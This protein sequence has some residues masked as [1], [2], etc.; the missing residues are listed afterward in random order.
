MTADAD[1]KKKVP[2]RN[3][4]LLTSLVG[5]TLTRLT[6]YSWWPTEESDREENVSPADVFSLTAG[7]VLL[8]FDTGLI[9]CFGS[10]P[11]LISVT[12]W[13]DDAGCTS[14]DLELHAI[15]AG[16][17]Q[18]SRALFAQMVGRKV[19]RITLLKRAP[20]NAKWEER[21]REVGLIIRFDGANDLVLAHGLHDDSDDF[22]VLVREQVKESLWS[23][24]SEVDIGRVATRADKTSVELVGAIAELGG[25]GPSV[26]EL[27]GKG[28]FANKEGLLSYLRRG[29][30]L[31]GSPA[32]MHDPLRPDVLAGA[33]HIR[34]DGRY[35][36]HTWL[37]Y[38]VKNYDVALPAAFLEHV[39]RNGYEV[40]DDIDTRALRLGE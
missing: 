17:P 32:L 6:R 31:I 7:P 1:E 35:A 20:K 21:P 5:A 25:E 16:D 29:K 37:E 34:T 4:E 18:H 23:E 33:N 19:T 12:M 9:L 14:G 36:W 10:Q 26:S 28:T 13:K 15:D 39:E 22:A 11:S 30:L 3:L 40:P 27:R 38:F 2:S 24:M 8:G